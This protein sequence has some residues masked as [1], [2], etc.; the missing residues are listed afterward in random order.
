MTADDEEWGEDRLQAAAEAVRDLPAKDILQTLFRAADEF[1]AG[2]PQHDDMTLLMLRL[3][4]E[5]T[6]PTE[7]GLAPILFT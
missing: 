7:P 6:L 2:A 1:T 5:P 4:A 3:N